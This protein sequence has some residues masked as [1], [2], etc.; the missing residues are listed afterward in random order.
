MNEADEVN[1]SIL[2]CDGSVQVEEGDTLR[3]QSFILLKTVSGMF[4]MTSMMYFHTG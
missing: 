4:L 3:L 2:P 1:E